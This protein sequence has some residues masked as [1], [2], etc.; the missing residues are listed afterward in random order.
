MNRPDSR[1]PTNDSG[2]TFVVAILPPEPARSNLRRVMERRSRQLGSRKALYLP[3]HITIVGRFRTTHAQQLI[4]Q[5][6]I[7]C[8]SFEPF[9]MTLKTTKRFDAPKI[10]YFDAEN[11]NVRG[12]HDGLLEIVGALREPWTRDEMDTTPRPDRQQELLAKYG[13]PYVKEFYV[14]HMTIAGPDVDETWDE[15]GPMTIEPIAFPVKGIVLLERTERWRE[16]ERI[17]FGKSE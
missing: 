14:P 13:S 16:A 17:P 12:L 10:E 3:P 7:W 6:R 5:M 11:A 2:R 8:Q 1:N 4:A 15:G 9:I